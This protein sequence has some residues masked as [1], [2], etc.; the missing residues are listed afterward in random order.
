MYFS[1]KA[2]APSPNADFA[3]DYWYLSAL[4]KS[5]AE[6]RHADTLSAGSRLDDDRVAAFIMSALAT[7]ALPMGFRQ[8]LG[9]RKA[10]PLFR[11]P[12]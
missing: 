12:P 6:R 1:T 9:S 4:S 3:R 11:Q 5:S 7:S 8:P 10:Q 2:R